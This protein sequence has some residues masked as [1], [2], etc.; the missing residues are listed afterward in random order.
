MGGGR[1]QGASPPVGE[2]AEVL[3]L[4]SRALAWSRVSRWGTADLE[5]DP[6]PAVTGRPEEKVNG[7]VSRL[8][9]RGFAQIL[10]RSSQSYRDGTYNSSERAYC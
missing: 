7:I 10:L 9:Q 2:D 6:I 4:T 1:R 3:R 8:T 5:L